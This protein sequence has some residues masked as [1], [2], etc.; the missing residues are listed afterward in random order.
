MI[1]CSFFPLNRLKKGI[2]FVSYDG[3][4]NVDSFQ[5]SGVL[6]YQS[7]QFAAW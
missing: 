4:V 7:F 1:L 3:V 6:T 5:L 2:F